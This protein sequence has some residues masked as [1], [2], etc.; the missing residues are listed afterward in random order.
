MPEALPVAGAVRIARPMF[1]SAYLQT[2]A[3][4]IRAAVQ[5]AAR[6]VISTLRTGQSAPFAPPDIRVGVAPVSAPVVADKLIFTTQ[7]R[8]VEPAAL[9]G[10]PADVST[11]F[12]PDLAPV[13][14]VAIAGPE[15]VRAAMQAAGIAI[16][17]LWAKEDA[18]A[19]GPARALGRVLNVDYVLL[20]R[21]TDIE[22]EEGPE[23]TASVVARQA[24]TQN[25]GLEQEARV[26]SVGALVRVSDGAVLWRDRAT[27]TMTAHTVH[28]DEPYS[29]QMARR[30][31][32]DATR[33]SLIDLSRRL[34]HYLDS[35]SQ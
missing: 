9:S 15:H 29:T 27:A 13:D 7:G 26:E 20:A 23:E 5:Q 35:F 33:F 24:L 18:P 11:L 28:T 31:A 17:A 6:G 2:Q 30:V 14:S 12:T 32:R 21:I 22:L 19:A 10:L 4:A 25:P 3:A 16:R 8:H 34:T 1:R